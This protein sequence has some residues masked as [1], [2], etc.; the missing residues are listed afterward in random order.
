MI[1]PIRCFTC[2][3]PIGHL[4]EKYQNLL[5]QGK[6]PKEAF[7]ELGIERMC[8]RQIFLGHVQQ[9]ELIAKYKKF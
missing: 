6:S 1:I 4:W 5:K 3:K 2:G 7:E 8:C 9:I